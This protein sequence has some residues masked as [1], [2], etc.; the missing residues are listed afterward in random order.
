MQSSSFLCVFVWEGVW[1]LGCV[2]A[3]SGCVSEGNNCDQ[4]TVLMV[5]IQTA[6]AA[7]P[8]IGQGMCIFENF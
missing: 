4:L 2:I 8:V 6:L 1:V 5:C 3:V 7:V